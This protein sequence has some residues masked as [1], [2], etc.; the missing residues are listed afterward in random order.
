MVSVDY[1]EEAT[2]DGQVVD[3]QETHFGQ[4]VLLLD[5]SPPLVLYDSLFLTGL[6]VSSNNIILREVLMKS[7]INWCS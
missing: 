7:A 6:V 5:T 1:I 3:T 2:P 4:G